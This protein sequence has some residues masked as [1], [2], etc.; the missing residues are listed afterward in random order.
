MYLSWIIPAHNEERRIEKT[1]REVSRYLQSKNFAYEIVVVDNAS[2]DTT[3]EII[4]R[5]SRELPGVRLLRSNGPGKGWAVKEGMLNARGEI[6]LFSDADNATSPEHFDRVAPMFQKGH[7]VVISSRNPKDAP[8]ATEDRPE[9]ALRQFAGKLG[10]VAIQLFA[11][12]GIWDTQNG[13]KAFRARAAENIFSRLTIFGF[14]F[15]IEVLVLTRRLHYKIGII[16]VQWKHD[17]D[18]KVTL[19]SYISVLLDVLRIRWNIIIGKYNGIK[20]KE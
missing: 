7:D 20:N 17:P 16:P 4:T 3:S 18:S 6:R 11:V 14:A 10:N 2:G 9:G 1:V 5:L 12:W 15:D 8:G 19:G 13:F